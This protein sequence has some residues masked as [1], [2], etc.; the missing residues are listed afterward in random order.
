MKEC[1]KC[2]KNK[3]L[4][5]Y[6]KHKDMADGYLNKCKDC[7]KKDVNNRYSKLRHDPEYM[8]KER[9][10]GREKYKRLNYK[11]ADY[12][13]KGACYTSVYTNQHRYFKL[14]KGLEVHHWSYRSKYMRD[15]FVLPISEHRYIHRLMKFDNNS[16]CFITNS[17]ELLDTREKHSRFIYTKLAQRQ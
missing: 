14:E 9:A 7:T 13:A 8:E 5:D 4:T 15:I 1:F 3:P 17:G 11:N 10:R 2:K 16:L 12:K 6:Y